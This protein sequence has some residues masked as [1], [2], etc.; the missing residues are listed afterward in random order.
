MMESAYGVAQVSMPGTADLSPEK[1]RAN[2]SPLGA[3]TSA[4][5]MPSLLSMSG[6]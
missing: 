3:L 2:R 1:N 6:E 4:S 5:S